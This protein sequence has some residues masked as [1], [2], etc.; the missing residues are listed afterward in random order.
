VQRD[1]PAQPTISS[2]WQSLLL[3]ASQVWDEA[4][5]SVI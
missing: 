4:L 5:A 1:A 3:D 2:N